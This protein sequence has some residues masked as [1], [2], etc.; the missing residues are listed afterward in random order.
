MDKKEPLRFIYI[1]DSFP[2]LNHQVGI[3]TLEISKRLVKQNI[4]PIIL[5][6]KIKKNSSLNYSFM[7]SIP[8]SLDIY[9][10]Y[11]FESKNRYRFFLIFN[12]FRLAFYLGCI[13]LFFLKIKRILR[14]NKTVKFIYASGP[15][16]Y[17]FIIG[18]LLK[19]KYLLPLVVEY[20][21][22]WSFNPYSEEH[23]QKL[24]KRIDSSIEKRILSFAD[25]IITVSPALKS[26]LQK[27]FPIISKKSIFSIASG[28]NINKLKNYSRKNPQEI[29]FT[30]TGTLYYKRNIEPL[31]KIISE[32][33]QEMFFK[34]I[35]FTLKIYGTTLGID[36]HKLVKKY[37]L[38]DLVLI[39]GLIP[40]TKA[41]EE[42]KKSDLAVHIGEN[43]NYP[44]IA[45]KVWDYLS[46]RK[47]ILYLGREDSY[48]AY[49]LKNNNFGITL[50]LE[51]LNEGKFIL[52]DLLNDLIDSNF[53]TI[54]EDNLINDFTWDKRV[55]EFI[56]KVVNNFKE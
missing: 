38:K 25:I 55:K 54:I 7:N 2:P 52:R 33:K 3:R 50:P 48:T 37:N 23:V 40:R 41:L 27:N 35:N 44:T 28:L 5:T 15:S 42:I 16:F 47:K 26:F 56:N 20:R 4:F 39:G 14:K 53:K 10:S 11:L 45:F 49:F 19:K 9:R 24:I 36:L 21:D 6:Q 18:Y 22:P 8:E 12:F 29:I 46:C 31:L 34:D 51:D 32:L 1:V 13:P 30:F 17:T 43:L